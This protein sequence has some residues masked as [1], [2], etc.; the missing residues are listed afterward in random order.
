MEAYCGMTFLVIFAPWNPEQSSKINWK[1]LPSRF[2]NFICFNM[3]FWSKHSVILSVPLS[4]NGSSYS[5]WYLTYNTWNTYLPFF[6]LSLFSI[7]F[8][9][10]F[11]HSIIIILYIRSWQEV[12]LKSHRGGITACASIRINNNQGVV[13]N[14]IYDST[15]PWYYTYMQGVVKYRYSIWRLPAYMYTCDARHAIAIALRSF[16][17]E[18]DSVLGL[19]SLQI[20]AF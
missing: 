17:F 14:F 10:C 11:P 7:F 20:T 1:P 6:S 13:N 19:N 3:F 4:K 18:C 9:F 15:S 5:Q 12:A 2:P 16:S 8:F